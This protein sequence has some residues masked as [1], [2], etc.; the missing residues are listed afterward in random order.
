MIKSELVRCIMLKS[1]SRVA[2]RLSLIA[3]V[4]AGDL[5]LTRHGLLAHPSLAN[6]LAFTS[7]RY[8]PSRRPLLI[9]IIGSLRRVID[10]GSS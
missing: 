1:I 2:P 4:L 8:T 10:D 7:N 3:H 5:V 6:P 9:P